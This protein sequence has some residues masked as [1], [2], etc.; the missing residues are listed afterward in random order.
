MPNR[1]T[2][3]RWRIVLEVILLI[4]HIALVMAIFRWIE[5]RKI[6]GVVAGGFFLEIGVVVMALEWW[7]GRGPRSLA[8]WAAAIFLVGSAIPVMALRLTHWEVP[9]DEIQW[10]GV[11]GRQLHQMSNGTYIAILLMAVIE[12]LRDRGER[13]GA[14]S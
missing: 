5:D 6:A 12:A 9:F 11:T 3:R 4:M 10:L 8:F 14:R 13:S 7:W 1:E 2:K